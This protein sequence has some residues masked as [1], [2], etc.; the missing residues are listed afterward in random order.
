MFKDPIA[1]REKKEGK[2]PWNFEA[3]QYDQRSS[4]FVSAGSHYGV[5][6]NQ[7]VGTLK[8]TK[9]YAVPM[10]KVSTMAVDEKG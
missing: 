8:V 10:G 7:P 6:F 5:G 1:P 4:N 3:P 9:G 2:S